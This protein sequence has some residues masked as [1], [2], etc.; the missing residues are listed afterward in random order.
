MSRD[1]R[2]TATSAGR[3][4]AYCAAAALVATI[5][6]FAL[7]PDLWNRYLPE[8]QLMLFGMGFLI[9]FL[10]WEAGSWLTRGWLTDSR[11]R[12]EDTDPGEGGPR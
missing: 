8:R 6:S 12:H 11:R 5:V 1:D 7:N 2:R 3:R 9:F 4:H 10:V